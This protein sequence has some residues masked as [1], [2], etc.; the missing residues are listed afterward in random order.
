MQ[1]ENIEKSETVRFLEWIIKNPVRWD[2]LHEG[3]TTDVIE[4][5]ELLLDFDTLISNGL[6]SVMYSI[7]FEDVSIITERVLRKMVAQFILNRINEIGELKT[8]K[9]T[10]DDLQH[11]WKQVQKGK[12]RQEI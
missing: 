11:E 8:A 2:H 4:P 7:M 10:L 5:E 1:N 9:E 6:Y 3:R 12:E